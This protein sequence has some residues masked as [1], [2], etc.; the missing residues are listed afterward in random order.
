VL[1][2]IWN[3]TGFDGARIVLESRANGERT[4][5]VERASYGRVV[6]AAGEAWL[7]YARPEG[8]HA[9]PFDLDRLRVSGAAMPVVS[10]VAVN[11][12]GGAHYSVSDGGLLAFIPGSLDEANKTALWVT[13]QGLAAAIGVVPGLGFSYRLSPDGQR[14]ARPGATGP[15]R[16][17]WIDDLT[18]IGTPIRLTV[19]R[20]I[21]DP[22]WTP[23][24]LRVIYAADGQLFSRA[25]DGSG[26]EERLPVSA[27]LLNVGSVSPDGNTLAYSAVVTDATPPD[28]WLLALNGDSRP[29]RKVLDTP[30]AELDPRISPDGRWVAYRSNMSGAFEIY[31]TAM[32]GDGRQIAVSN[33]GGQAPRW[34]Q[35]GREL[36]FRDRD[37]ATGGNMMVVSVDLSGA[38]PQLGTPQVL[39]PSPYQG[40]GDIGPDGRFLLL[41]PTPLESPSRVIQLVTNWFEDLRAKVPQ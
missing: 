7:V 15:A 1:Y 13:R 2:T 14:L 22:T 17:L 27:R 18:R 32:A 5:L 25:A 30:F 8:L 39:F 16:D 24:G 23:D 34:R 31:L 3:N 10:D 19:G 33:G 28:L 40:D 26:A 37:P 38:E 11:M 20:A 4:V 36:Y 35:D 12:S 41:K 9:A 6:S 29:P 21:I